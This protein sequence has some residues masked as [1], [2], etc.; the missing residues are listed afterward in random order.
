MSYKTT[1]IYIH[2]HIYIRIRNYTQNIEQIYIKIRERQGQLLYIQQQLTTLRPCL[3]EKMGLCINSSTFLLLQ[4]LIF[5][6]INLVLQTVAQINWKRHDSGCDYFV[7]KWV[8]DESYPLYNASTCP[9]VEREFSCQ[10]NGRPDKTYLNYRWQPNAC[11]LLR[12]YY[13]FSYVSLC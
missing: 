8:F 10:K 4:L 11:N 2:I 13:S 7:G 12:Y 5:I 1:D 9:L 6:F 3:A